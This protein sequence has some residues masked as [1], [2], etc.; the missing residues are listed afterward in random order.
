MPK[1]YRFIPVRRF[2]PGA[3]AM[4]G[5]R[6]LL[7]AGYR[8]QSANRGAYRVWMPGSRK[9]RTMNM[10]GLIKILDEIRVAKGLEPILKP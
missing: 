1:I 5:D 6:I 8:V 2:E 10:R 9:P 3:S 7:D 4:G